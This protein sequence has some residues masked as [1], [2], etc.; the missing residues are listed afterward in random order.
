MNNA[1]LSSSDKAELD[2]WLQ[3]QDRQKV[4]RHLA[5]AALRE[6]EHEQQEYGLIDVEEIN[7]QEPDTVDS[8]E[9]VHQSTEQLTNLEKA[10][11]KLSV[12]HRNQ[13]VRAHQA[14][15]LDRLGY[16]LTLQLEEDRIRANSPKAISTRNKTTDFLRSKITETDNDLA[17][18]KTTTPEAWGAINGLELR[19]NVQEIISGKLVKTPYVEKNLNRVK[20]NIKR[21]QPTFIHGH[22]GSGKTELAITAAKE[23]TAER[24]ARNFAHEEYAEWSAHEKQAGHTTS[25]AEHRQYLAKA[26]KRNLNK[27][28]AQF[29]SGDPELAERLSPLIISGSKDL[30]SQ[31]LYSEK[32][33]KLT[34]FNGKSILE[35]KKDLDAE[36]QQWQDDNR[37][38]LDTM[39]EEERTKAIAEASNKILEIYKL[40]N[41]AFGT[42]VDTIQKEIYRGVLEGRPVVIDEVNAIPSAVLI[43]MNDILQRRPGQNCFIPGVGSVQI[44]P[45]FSIIMTGNLTSNRITYEGTNDL[46]PAFLSRLDAFEH[47][48]L[49][50]SCEDRGYQEQLNPQQ[51][52]LFRVMLTHMVDTKGHLQLP[53]ME[54]S[55]SQIFSLAQL[56]RTTQDIFSEKWVES[57][58][59]TNASGDEVEPRLEKAVLS[60]R[61]IISV[62]QEWNKGSD[63]NLDMALWDGF[64]SR[65]TNPDDQNLILNIAK[66]YN[67]FKNSEGWNV[68]PKPVGA[69]SLT[70]LSEIRTHEYQHELKPMDTM[71]MVKVLE[72]MFGQPPMRTEYPDVN[73]L[74][75]DDLVNAETEITPEEY[76]E[77][78]EQQKHFEKTLRALE[79]LAMKGCPID[80]PAEQATD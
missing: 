68:Q 39:T 2:Q 13:A 80:N 72:C 1:E 19:Q 44:Q 16:D 7:E 5:H 11:A 46:N 24:M 29:N 27:I 30:T 66:T 31:D 51:N 48:Y 54:K 41:Q 38:D 56:A 20:N 61:N 70:S 25:S 3:E 35:H 37:A 18:L 79:K 67:F 43:S 33:L 28:T 9:Q 71:P 52:E 12:E 21:G 10:M 73:E 78:A 36:L 49:P 59:N 69:S 4:E 77:L 63:K 75:F 32:T 6:L 17:E 58:V 55:L 62:L 14:L 65:I 57:H 76:I 50:Q 64:I 34:K 8:L 60:M 22:L 15:K 23:I 45:G 26:Y 40:K 74:E 53:E 47:D 42:E